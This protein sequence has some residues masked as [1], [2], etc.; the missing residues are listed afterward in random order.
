[1]RAR[2]ASCLAA[3]TLLSTACAPSD[4]DFR[5]FATYA[6]PDG[7]YRVVVLAANSKLAFGPHTLKVYS[8]EQDNGNRVHV[9]TTS[10]A[11][12]GSRLDGSNVSVSWIRPQV[13]RFCLSGAEQKDTVLEIDLRTR[14]QDEYEQACS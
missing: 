10:L 13:I 7:A 4:A 12:D 3:I 1:M 9:V 14:S 6:S 8:V 2:P 11:N 5:E